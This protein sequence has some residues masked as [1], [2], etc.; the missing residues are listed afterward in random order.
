MDPRAQ[1]GLVSAAL[2]DS[3]WHVRP[4]HGETLSGDVALVLPLPGGV[5]LGVVDVLGHGIEA[6]AVAR[7]AAA[8]LRRE[9]SP[10][11]GALLQRLHEV[12]RGTLGAAAGLCWVDEATGE[13]RWAGVGNV[14][15]RMA[16]SRELRMAGA[17]GV[18]GHVL[19]A[20][21]VHA[22]GL[23]PGD[24]VLLCSDGIRE[25]VGVEAYPGL[26]GDSAAYV[27]RHVVDCFGREHDDATC[28]ALRRPR[29]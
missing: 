10:D 16:G 25:Q 18:L 29:A 28:V 12:L 15:L 1:V 9:A 27:A 14:V 3:A 4:C 24:L 22:L 20:V 5:L 26:L 13:A 23:A 2:L 17:D 21:R 19:P 6:H 11:V 7:E 8:W